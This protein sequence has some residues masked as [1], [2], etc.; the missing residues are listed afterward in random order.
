[1]AVESRALLSPRASGDLEGD[2][3]S[4]YHLPKSVRISKKCSYAFSSSS[5]A[6]AIVLCVLLVVTNIAWAYAFAYASKQSIDNYY[7]ARD[8][9]TTF[10]FD[11]NGL[12][13]VG[14]ESR[15]A[16]RKWEGVFPYGGGRVALSQDIVRELSLPAS[17]PAAQDPEKSVYQ[18]AGYHQLHCL[19]KI[20]DVLHDISDLQGGALLKDGAEPY[21]NGTNWDHVL[22]CVEALRQGLVCRIDE[23]LLPVKETWPPIGDGSGVQRICKNVSTLRDWAEKNRGAENRQ[24]SLDD[25]H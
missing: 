16:D 12:R 23:T 24:W 25:D 8:V 20:R 4:D 9:Q 19:D 14:N 17:A 13:P 11:W 10:H 6:P 15:Y 1:M 18:I 7:G 2:R 5:K 21:L 3:D 22:H